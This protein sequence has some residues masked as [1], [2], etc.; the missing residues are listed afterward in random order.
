[1]LPASFVILKRMDHRGNSIT[2]L[3]TIL[4]P[5]KHYPSTQYWETYSFVDYELDRC[6][7]KIMGAPLFESPVRK[8]MS[9]M[10]ISSMFDP[11]QNDFSSLSHSPIKYSS[12]MTSFLIFCSLKYFSKPSFHRSSF[13]FGYCKVAISLK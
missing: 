13:A 11:I 5:T 2:Y 9:S 6:L 10:P 12:K 4:P 3:M 1:M 7:D 8:Y